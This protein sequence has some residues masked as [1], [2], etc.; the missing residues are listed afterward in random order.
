[1][2]GRGYA[3]IGLPVVTVVIGAVVGSE[4]SS[5]PTSVAIAARTTMGMGD[6]KQPIV[7]LPLFGS[8]HVVNLDDAQGAQYLDLRTTFG[9]GRGSGLGFC[10]GGRASA[11]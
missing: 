1:M 8:D 2:R 11:S 4:G 3:S 5:R 6:A 7:G 10:C 9:G